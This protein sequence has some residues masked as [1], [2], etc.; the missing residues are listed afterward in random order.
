MASCSATS[1]FLDVPAGGERTDVAFED[2][3][4]SAFSAL[5]KVPPP[6]VQ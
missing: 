3:E 4:L 5:L 1:A 6:E 2:D